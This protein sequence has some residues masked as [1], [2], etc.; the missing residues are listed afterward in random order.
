MINLQ[1]NDNCPLKYKV[2]ELLPYISLFDLKGFTLKCSDIIELTDNEGR[3]SPFYIDLNIYRQRLSRGGKKSE[4]IARA[5]IGKL[6]KP[7]VID[8]TAG[9]GRDALILQSAGANVKMFERNPIIY[10]LLQDALRRAFEDSS[11]L[12]CLPNGL[13]TLMPYGSLKD[14]KSLHKDFDADVIYYDPMFPQRQKS[15]QVKKEMQIFHEI[16]GFD[17][18]NFSYAEYLK[19]VAKVRLVIKRPANAE[20]ILPFTYQVDGKA[21]RFDCIQL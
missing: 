14:Y 2:K 11:F 10:I 9:L 21:C 3:F 5:V 13:P 6:K 19:S 8:A 15:A 4:S 20:P 1:V 18:D 17:E 7:D 12:S 16:V